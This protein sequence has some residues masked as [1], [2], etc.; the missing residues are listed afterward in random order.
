MD[1]E[2]TWQGQLEA[3]MQSAVAEAVMASGRETAFVMDFEDWLRSLSVDRW[4]GDAQFSEYLFDRLG[5]F[6]GHEVNEG[7]LDATATEAHE[8]DLWEP[9][10]AVVEVG[11]EARYVAEVEQGLREDLRGHGL[12]DTPEMRTMTVEP[13]EPTRGID[14]RSITERVHDALA[15]LREFA[16][17]RDTRDRGQGLER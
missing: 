15:A 12:H 5:Q 4:E 7:V 16:L 2:R 14:G 13:D 17:G 6:L 9:L 11:L 8:A 1:G 3:F 10:S